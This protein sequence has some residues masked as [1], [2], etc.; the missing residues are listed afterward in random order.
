MKSNKISL[1]LV[2]WD[3]H[4]PPGAHQP[5]MFNDAHSLVY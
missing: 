5:D 1:F 3:I 2:V 4:L